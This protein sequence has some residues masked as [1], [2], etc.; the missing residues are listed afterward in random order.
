MERRSGREGRNTGCEVP[1][2]WSNFAPSEAL[3]SGILS[4][5]SCS[6]GHR[7]WPD[8]LLPPLG[9]MLQGVSGLGFI[10]ANR[11]VR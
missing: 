3:L 2:N 9:Q 5:P 7:L 1:G 10:A 11:Q 6:L 8:L 4:G